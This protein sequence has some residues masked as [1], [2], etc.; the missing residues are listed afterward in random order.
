MKRLLIIIILIVFSLNISSQPIF[1]PASLVK[2]NKVYEGQQKI[3]PAY[4]LWAPKVFIDSLLSLRNDTINGFVS[5]TTG[6]STLNSRKYIPTINFL[7][8]YFSGHGGDGTGDMLKLVYDTDNDGKVDTSE[9]SVDFRN[10][11]AFT[12]DANDTTWWGARGSAAV[13]STFESIVVGNISTGD[14]IRIDENGMYIENI[15]SKNGMVNILD[16]TNF[17]ANMTVQGDVS[18]EYNLRSNGEIDLINSVSSD[19]TFKA[20]TLGNVDITG[21]YRVNGVPISGGSGVT[22]S[23]Y[24]LASETW[25]KNGDTIK[26]DTIYNNIYVDNLHAENNIYSNDSIIVTNGTVKTKFYENVDVGGIINT[27]GFAFVNTLGVQFRENEFSGIADMAIRHDTIY[28]NRYLK[29]TGGSNISG[30]SM[31]YPGAGIP[32]S[33]GSAWG[34]SITNNSANWNTAYGWGNH[35]TAEYADSTA[36]VDSIAIVKALADSALALI[37]DAQP[38][39]N[40]FYTKTQIDSIKQ[41]VVDSLGALIGIGGIDSIYQASSGAWTTDTITK[42]TVYNSITAQTVTVDTNTILT[43]ESVTTPSISIGDQT[44]IL[45]T[46]NK[47]EISTDTL[48]VLLT[49]GRKIKSYVDEFTTLFSNDL[50][51]IG[52]NNAIYSDYLIFGN[53]DIELQINNNNKNFSFKNDGRIYFTGDS[54]FLPFGVTHIPSSG[55]HS[56]VYDSDSGHVGYAQLRTTDY[57]E[58]TYSVSGDDTVGGSSAGNPI[59]IVTQ[60]QWVNVRIGENTWSNYVASNFTYD[61]DTI[62]YDSTSS[63]LNLYA[64][65]SLSGATHGYDFRW[66]NLTDGTTLAVRKFTPAAYPTWAAISAIDYNAD[67]N[68]RYVLQTRCLTGTNDLILYDGL[69]NINDK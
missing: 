34:T 29:V 18:V 63:K 43:G 68:D 36:T 23:L 62:Q 13:D 25:L 44:S 69:I 12:I 53:D 38:A 39:T 47:T 22:D 16:Q 8:D 54:T 1:G 49:G 40:Y 56:L 41:H 15:Y 17:D 26:K 60:Y 10:S 28:A 58:A 37:A 24:S 6:Y 9:V 48:E 2:G 65:L 45:D 21:E 32:L 61:N 11:L 51:K 30:G 14:T 67:K 52:N 59:D 55:V 31:V 46:N 50:F 20:D 66:R 27:T 19:T 42:D 33:T 64:E 5:D 57:F 7:E 35:A 4:W 3:L